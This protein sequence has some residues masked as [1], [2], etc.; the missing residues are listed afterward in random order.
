MKCFAIIPFSAGPYELQE[1]VFSGHDVIYVVTNGS[2]SEPS[3]G[4]DIGDYDVLMAIM[5]IMKMFRVL[6][7]MALIVE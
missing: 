6:V 1:S 7:L 2:Q 5:G 3:I 4:D